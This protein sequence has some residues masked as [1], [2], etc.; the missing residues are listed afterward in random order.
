[1]V[2]LA[3]VRLRHNSTSRKK[4][5]PCLM[6]NERV[7]F[8]PRLI[9]EYPP[10]GVVWR[11]QPIFGTCVLSTEQYHRPKSTLLSIFQGIPLALL[12]DMYS[13]R[14]AVSEAL[15][16]GEMRHCLPMQ[17][18]RSFCA[19]MRRVPG[20]SYASC[21]AFFGERIVVCGRM[22]VCLRTTSMVGFGIV[23]TL[24]SEAS[25]VAKIQF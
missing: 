14:S 7:A 4:A 21:S 10:L 16:P 2:F 18:P 19:A 8:W 15:L 9:S 5:D 17:R 20:I 24:S 6:R 3:E 11:S 13:T 22:S 25:C 23:I 1:M 12:E